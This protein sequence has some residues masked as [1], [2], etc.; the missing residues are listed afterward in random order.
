MK[1][2]LS[3]NKGRRMRMQQMVNHRPLAGL[4]LLDDFLFNALLAYP[5]YGRE[6]LSKISKFFL[7]ES[8][9]I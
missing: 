3:P 8:S 7:E 9:E 5:E 1:T 4:D 6:I 2:L